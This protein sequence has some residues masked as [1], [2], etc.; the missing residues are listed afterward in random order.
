MRVSKWWLLIGPALIVV[1]FTVAIVTLTDDTEPSVPPREPFE[2]YTAPSGAFAVRVQFDRV[3]PVHTGV[4]ITDSLAADG[5]AATLYDGANEYR[6]TE[7]ALPGPERPQGIDHCRSNAP[8]ASVSEGMV[9][10]Q[11]ATLCRWENRGIYHAEAYVRRDDRVFLIELV[12]TSEND[13]R[14]HN[15]LAAF[16]FMD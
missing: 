3:V 11:V 7:V 4:V 6:L 14:F 9:D 8:D 1:A 15:L 12:S 16:V 5:D 2:L 10:G 13:D